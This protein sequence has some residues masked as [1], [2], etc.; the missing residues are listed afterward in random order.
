MNLRVDVVFDVPAEM[1]D[2]FQP[3]LDAVEHAAAGLEL[4]AEVRVVRTD[5]IDDR[6]FDELPDAV[7]IGPGS[8]YIE[9]DAAE[10]VIRTAR[11]KGL[12][13]VGT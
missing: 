8:P 1:T 13:L 11:E 12:P 9:P 10:R 4:D 5:T 6:Y 7:V 2:Y 3:T